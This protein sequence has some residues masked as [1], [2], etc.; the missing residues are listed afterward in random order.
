[1]RFLVRTL[2]AIVSLVAV[3]AAQA[4]QIKP[5]DKATFDALQTAGKPVESA[6]RCR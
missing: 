4:A 6:P 1:M 2:F 3:S 5:Y